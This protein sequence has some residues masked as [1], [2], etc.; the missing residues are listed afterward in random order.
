MLLGGFW[1][2]G[3]RGRIRVVV[4]GGRMKISMSVMLNFKCEPSKEKFKRAAGYMLEF[5]RQHWAG[6]VSFG[7]IGIHVV[8]E[9]KNLDRCAK[10]VSLDREE[11]RG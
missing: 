9:A 10:G 11:F 8:D 1:D 2:R 4:G 7:V 3:M 5:Q 6:N